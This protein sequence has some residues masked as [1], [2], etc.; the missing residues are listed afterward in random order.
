MKH[1]TIITSVALV[2]FSCAAL[3]SLYVNEVTYSLRLDSV[4]RPK[5]AKERWGEF[6]KLEVSEEKK[7]HYEDD[8]IDSYLVVLPDRIA[9]EIKNKTDHSIKLIWDDAAFID[10]DGRASRIMH[11][12]VKYV[13]RNA[14]QPSSM[15]PAHGKF[16]DVIL[17]TDRIFYREGYYGTV[18]SQPGGWKH[19]A[20]IQP[21]LELIRET[22][23][24]NV[25]VTDTLKA[26]ATN[27]IGKKIGILLPLEI[28]GTTNEYTFWFKVTDYRVLQPV[29]TYKHPLFK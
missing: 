11:G 26:N 29:A 28:Q 9:F 5:E 14:S 16:T 10:L 19:L 18:V 13:D 17:P 3:S 27:N 21:Q 4:E 20:L 1:L 22:S 23:D 7:Y 24:A 8:L 2:A 25:T 15:I 6:A 12:G